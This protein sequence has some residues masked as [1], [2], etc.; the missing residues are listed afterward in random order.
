MPS[1][2]IQNLANKTVTLP[3]SVQSIIQAFAEQGIDWMQAC[4]QKGRCTTCKM[5]VLEG[6]EQMS[7]P[8]EN[9]QRMQK[10][11]RLPEGYR[12]ACQCWVKSGH[13]LVRVPD[14]NKL[15]HMQYSE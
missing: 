9:E 14:V 8:S 4:G 7:A 12:L 2:T 3:A 1:I 13:V 5:K 10:L 11:G 15:P 6:E